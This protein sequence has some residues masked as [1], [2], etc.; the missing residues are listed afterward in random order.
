MAARQFV[1]FVE[2]N[3]G[4]NYSVAAGSIDAL[5]T[6]NAIQDLWYDVLR[7]DYEDDDFDGVVVLYDTVNRKRVYYYRG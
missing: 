3:D 1:Y 5:S 4:N 6:D 7:F 2:S